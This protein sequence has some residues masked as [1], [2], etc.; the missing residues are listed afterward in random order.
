MSFLLSH[1]H[2]V[3]PV[4]AIIVAVAFM[5]DKPKKDGAQR[6]KAKGSLRN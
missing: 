5:R 2:C 1:W 6:K 3:L 4:A